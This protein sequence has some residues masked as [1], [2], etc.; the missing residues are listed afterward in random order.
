MGAI[1]DTDRSRSPVARGEGETR[2]WEP[3]LDELFDSGILKKGDLEDDVIEDLKG[4]GDKE[5]AHAIERMK[6]TEFDK[7]RNT[8]AFCRG[9]IRRIKEYGVEEGDPDL[10]VL[11]EKIEQKMEELIREGKFEKTDI[12]HRVVH[13]MRRLSEEDRY[14]ALERYE[15]SFDDSIRSKQGFFMGIVKRMMSPRPGQGQRGG[16]RGG[17]FRDRQSR[18][19]S[20]NDRG[21]RRSHY[22]DRPRYDD[23]RG[24]SRYD[25]RY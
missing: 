24:G 6:G 20:Y 2:V 5:A 9:I 8:S 23:R 12:D 13:C 16:R 18:G 14:V 15:S 3:S 11:G 17:G 25:D 19:R 7:V 22:D 4:L 1:H 21:R 10:S